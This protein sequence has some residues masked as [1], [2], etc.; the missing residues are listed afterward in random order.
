VG[1]EKRMKPKLAGSVRLPSQPDVEVRLL[2][3]LYRYGHAVEP[4]VLY[5]QLADD[6]ALSQEQRSSRR[7]SS[8]ELAWNNLVRYA[9]RRLVDAGL[10]DR[11]APRG[12]WNLTARG[13]EKAA[14]LETVRS[15][16]IEDLIPEL[17]R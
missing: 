1:G 13:R 14:W 10:I 12:L 9:R 4:K 7:A 16:P 3:F 5:A 17:F 11:N 8:G 2:H 6:F 15:T